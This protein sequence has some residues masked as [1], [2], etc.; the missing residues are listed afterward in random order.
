MTASIERI[1]VE[2]RVRENPTTRRV[3]QRAPENVE[4]SVVD[5]ARRAPSGKRT[6]VLT[7]SRGQAI[8]PCPGT[9]NYLCCGYQIVNVASGCPLDCTYCILQ[10]Y[11][12]DSTLIVQ[13]DLETLLA[14]AGERVRAEPDRFFRL[15]T[16]E[17]ADSL[18]LDPL[19]GQ[20]RT[21]VEWV[22]ELPNA[23]LELKTKS[24]NVDDLLD[25]DH[26]GRTICAWSMNADRVARD[27]EPGAAT[28]DERLA[29][30][31]RCRDAGYRVAFHFD[32]IVLHD[33]WQEGYRATVRAIFNAVAPQDIAWISLGCFRYTP[34][35]EQ[36][37]RERFPRSSCINGE[38]VLGGDR[39][40]RYPQPVRVYV[41]RQMMES[42]RESGGEDAMV[43][44]CMENRAVW[45]RAMGRCPRDNDDLSSWLDERG[46]P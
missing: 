18:A 26:G 44:L 2:K 43:Y 39:K 40:M 16:G 27:E 30:A 17:F 35:L 46:R 37:I 11:L 7:R 12:G 28:L 1:I 32:P 22:R 34:G 36:T 4:V 9:P 19:T 33:G 10:G 20:A 8:K 42:I 23:V 25:V 41:Y 38:F 15:G 45:K 14:D 5:A 29:A 6:L 21:L 24:V 13:A 3:L 31:R